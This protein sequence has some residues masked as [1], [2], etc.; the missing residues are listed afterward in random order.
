MSKILVIEDEQHIRDTLKDILDYTGYEVITAVNGKKG[1]D[2]ILKNKPDLVLCD[3][4][5]P[6][7]NGFELLESINS[8]LQSKEIPPFLFLT[9]KV[10]IEEMRHGMNLGADDYICKPFAIEEVLKAIKVRLAKQK[11]LLLLNNQRNEALKVIEEKEKS[12]LEAN[13]KLQKEVGLRRLAQL[14]TYKSEERERKRISGELHDGLGQT[15]TAIKLTLGALKNEKQ[16]STSMEAVLI[17]SINMV[18]IAIREVREI[19][20]NIAPSVLS[21]FGLNASLTK[22]CDS[23]NL[24]QEIELEYKCTGEE[25]RLPLSQE[26][27][28]YRIA[29]E[30]LNNALKHSGANKISLEVSFRQKELVVVVKD[31]GNGFRID[32]VKYNGGTGILGMEER[33]ESAKFCINFESELTKG[34]EVIL[35]CPKVF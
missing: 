17:D 14:K 16:V 4:N 18:N 3:V 29:Q 19:S 30:A 1:Y 21:D 12:L 23:L 13:K 31:N 20:Q 5:M 22:V 24:N 28:A 11:N 27:Y 25:Y 8:H 15:L 6:E 32:E 34:T 10:E 35:K 2:S 26:V 7:L 33:A 9:A